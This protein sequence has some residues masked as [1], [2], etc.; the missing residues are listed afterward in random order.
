MHT[1]APEEVV[2]AI[3]GVEKAR[4][5]EVL[6]LE[7]LEHQVVDTDNKDFLQHF[8]KQVGKKEEACCILD[9]CYREGEKCWRSWPLP[10]GN[11]NP[12]EDECMDEK[13]L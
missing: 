7:K 4:E 10:E 6:M 11:H 1:P 9:T 5:A 13:G 3:V 8:G 2:V 12:W